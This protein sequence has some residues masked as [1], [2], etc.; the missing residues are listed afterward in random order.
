M[1][2]PGPL[3]TERKA[4]TERHSRRRAW[5]RLR[6]RPL[7]VSARTH[8]R[9]LIAAWGYCGLTVA[10]ATL[11]WLAS[12]QWWVA[13]VLLFIPRWPILV[14]APLL[15]LLVLLIRP[16]LIF[17]IGLGVLIALG[18]GMGYRIGWQGWFAHSRAP[19]LR[20]VTFN[21][22]A[23]ENPR[24]LAISLGLEPYHPDVVVLQECAPQLASPENWPP[25]W[26]VRFDQGIC[27]AGRFPV[28]EARTLERIRTGDQGG[29]GD[30]MLYRLQTEQGTINLGV[31]HLETP[32]KGLEQ[33][34][35]RAGISA[36]ERNVL[37]RDVGSRRL[38]R[39]LG[40]QSDSLIIAGDFNMPVESTIYRANWSRCNN[41][42]S[43]VGWGFGWT[44]IL[45][46]YSIRIDH[47][48]TCRGW[49]ALRAVVGPDLG[50][51]HRP[52]I[53]DLART[54]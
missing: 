51:D 25:N 13:T 28:V 44:R 50:S 54:Q 23:G 41:A 35:Y 19:A 4:R 46:K 1:P 38:S 6:Y 31:I 43:R 48:L 32:R 10:Y 16:R 53:V 27:I 14:P 52:L 15:A 24:I 3:R 39:W 11:L 30:V 17:P 26:T 29:T 36:M 7:Q 42:F 22:D 9:L 40:E 18:P 12:D 2:Q 37:V 47:V 5:P 33:L 21:V 20:L 8:R 34:G 45:P 49:T